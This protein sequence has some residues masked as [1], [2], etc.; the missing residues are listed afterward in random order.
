MLL[1]SIALELTVLFAF[2]LSLG[3]WTQE[4]PTAARQTFLALAVSAALWCIGEIAY[5]REL[6]P[7]AW[8][9]R[10][11]YLGVLSLPPFWMGMA[12]HAS[13]LDLARRVPWFP[14]MLLAP[15]ALPFGLMFSS[16]W[17]GLFVGTV[18]GELDVTGPLWW[19]VLA[20]SYAL[21]IAGSL[22]LLA[23]AFRTHPPHARRLRVGVALAALVPLAGNAW[24]V[25]GG[26]VG[27]DPTPVLFGVALLALRPALFGGGLL[28]ALPLSHHE[29]LEQLPL[30]VI[31]TDR[32]NVVVDLNPAAERRLGI[33][34]E[35]AIG[36]TL[37][38]VLSDVGAGVEADYTPIL[39]GDSEAG[40]LVLLDP[41][42]K[43]SL[44]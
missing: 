17:N 7:E 41:P 8:S 19:V 25:A 36:R 16:R 33:S 18:P 6:L 34:E 2:W 39:S 11:L 29:L 1:I 43:D 12:C 10:L 4:R 23:S 24:Y 27:I 21:V 9:D 13:R 14:A 15:M 44:P 22:V 37:E 26:M 40:Q 31:L 42:E 38:A 30:G 5:Y 28:D 20:Y 32:R 35:K 3:V